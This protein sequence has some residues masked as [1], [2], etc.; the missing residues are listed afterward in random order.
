MRRHHRAAQQRGALLLLSMLSRFSSPS[1]ALSVMRQELS[2]SE[3]AQVREVVGVIG[4]PS[5]MVSSSIGVPEVK[6]HLPS[7]TVF[8]LGAS[9]RHI[10]IYLLSSPPNRA[11]SLYTH[12]NVLYITLVI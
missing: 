8:Q 10:Y 4:S 11:P 7:D 6:T 12:K 9:W 3:M 1:Q 2:N 5:A